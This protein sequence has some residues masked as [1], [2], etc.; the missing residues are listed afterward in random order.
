MPIVYR[1]VPAKSPMRKFYFPGKVTV[2]IVVLVLLGALLASLDISLL[3]VSTLLDAAAFAL[4]VA[5]ILTVSYLVFMTQGLGHYQLTLWKI[6]DAFLANVL[7]QAAANFLL[8]KFG[9][10]TVVP[11]QM[12]THTT[13][14]SGVWY[15]LYDL[16]LYSALI[17]T[18]GGVTDNEALHESARLLVS[19]QSL[20]SDFSYIIIFA[21]AVATLTTHTDETK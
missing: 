3:F 5:G 7:A 6:T 2:F 12:F 14:A 9:F 19:A 17:F 18:G 15:A 10:I 13:P 20:W 1:H 8:W 21:A 11:T 4:G 16:L